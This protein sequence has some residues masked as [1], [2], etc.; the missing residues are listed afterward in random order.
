VI[1]TNIEFENIVSRV[2]AHG[3]KYL[4]FIDIFHGSEDSDVDLLGIYAL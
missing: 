1:P 4:M 2:R 3:Q